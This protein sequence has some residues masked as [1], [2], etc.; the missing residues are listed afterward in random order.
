MKGSSRFLITSILVLFLAFLFGQTRTDLEKRLE[1]NRKEIRK[2]IRV[3]EETRLKQSSSLQALSLLEEQ[4]N[5][6]TRLLETLGKEV[7]VISSQIELAN[8]DISILNAEIKEMKLEFS[9]LLYQSYKMRRKQSTI[10]FLLSSENFNQV[11]KRLHYIRDLVRYRKKQLRLIVA[12]QE[13]NSRNVFKLIQRK[14]S[15]M[16]LLREQQ[17][18]RDALSND[19]VKIAAMLE[20]LS[21]RAAELDRDLKRRRKI[22]EDLEK[23]IRAAIA[24]EMAE[25]EKNRKKQGTGDVAIVRGTTFERNKGSIPWPV[26]FGQVSQKFGLHQHPKLK[27][28]T[29]E[30]NG[31]NITSRDGEIVRCVFD[32]TVSAVL[33]IP[34]MHQSVLVKHDKY[35]T[36]YANLHDVVVERGQQV[37]RG[38]KLGI[39]RTNDEGIADF[40]FE[41][42]QGSTKLNPEDWLGSM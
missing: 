7:D 15:K 35:Y 40:H 19:Q 42:W 30:N 33:E 32:G 31:I 9:R 16:S 14:N 18:A 36:V 12:K 41:I 37:N 17:S 23:E 28:I 3:L 20:E 10:Y 21:G 29:T 39:V 26:K 5:Q 13:E 2:A 27:N 22:E 6:R 34:G 11:F 24:R 8:K 38:D 4:I 25:A 1:S